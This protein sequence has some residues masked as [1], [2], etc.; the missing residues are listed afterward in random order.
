MRTSFFV[1]AT[2]LAA[3]SLSFVGCGGYG[4]SSPTSPSGLD[5]P[6]AGAIVI[7]VVRENGAQSFSP[8]PGTVPP[9]QLA[10]WHNI[11]TTTHHVVLNDGR[12][13][14]GNIAPGRYSA[15]MILTAAGPYH[16]TIH[17]DMVGTIVS[18]Q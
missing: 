8:N 11:D 1:A 4:N 17:P 7:N 6:P 12:L 13:D 3:L 18:G 2:G 5:A 16:C 10:S 14:A 9:G 15:A